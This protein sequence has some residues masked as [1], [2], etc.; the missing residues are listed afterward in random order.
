MTPTATAANVNARRPYQPGVIAAAR[1]ARVD[2]H[3]RLPRPAAQRRAARKRA[4][5]PRPTTR[6]ARRSRT[7]TTRAAACRRSRTRLGST[8]ERGRTSSDRTHNFVLSRRLAADYFEDSTGLVRRLARRLDALGDR[9]RCRAARRSRSRP[10]RTET[11]TASPTTAPTS[12]ATRRSTAA[13]R[14]R[15]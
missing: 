8:L 12:S 5:R 14:A 3:Q 9:A 7:S 6:S 15:S 4:S 13:A 11:S 1:R 2:L 10:G